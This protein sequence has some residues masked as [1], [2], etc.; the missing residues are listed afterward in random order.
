MNMGASWS[1]L[2][3]SRNTQDKEG[4]LNTKDPGLYNRESS[5][6][7]RMANYALL[8]KRPLSTVRKIWFDDKGKAWIDN[9][10]VSVSMMWEW[11]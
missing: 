8:R 2:A 9:M 6:F 4:L 7:L 11:N 3:A 1:P 10:W 5:Q